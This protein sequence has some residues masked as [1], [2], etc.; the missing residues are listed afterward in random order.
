MVS[1]EIATRSATHT[2]ESR[3][4][5]RFG[6]GSTAKSCGWFI[7]RTSEAPSECGSS[8]NGPPAIS[9][10]A[11]VEASTPVRWARSES[12]RSPPSRRS[13]TA[14]CTPAACARSSS[15]AVRNASASSRTWTP[16]PRSTSANASCSSCARSTQ[17]IESNRSWS[18]LRGVRRLSS[19]P[20][21]C[22]STAR[23]G[24]TSLS[25]RGGISS[26][27][28][29]AYSPKPGNVTLQHG[30]SDERHNVEDRVGDDQGPEPVRLLPDAAE[31]QAHHEVSDEPAESLI[32]V[33]RPAQHG[34]GDQR[35]VL[36][37][38]ELAQAR[39]QVADDQDLLGEGVA[40]GG[41]GER[42]RA[43]PGVAQSG[44]LHVQAEPEAVR[45]EVQAQP[46]NPDHRGQREG[47]QHVRPG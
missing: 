16:R 14:A 15:R 30:I 6:S 19:L 11:S 31:D 17:G 8:S 27:T 21:R 12:A 45:Q 18:L 28:R 43:P 47:A 32:Q 25:T 46:G 41:Q 20:G 29:R 34:R 3:V 13:S 42:D 37:D 44:R 26:F 5:S 23:S 24:P 9:T 1:D 4:N 36:P 39:Q 33:V 35:G 7:I 40:E 22:S 10:A 38:V 2:D